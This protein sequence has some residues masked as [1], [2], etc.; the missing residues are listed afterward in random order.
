MGEASSLVCSID[1]GAKWR[2][3]PSTPHSIDSSKRA[4]SRQSSKLELPCERAAPSL[5][6]DCARRCPRAQRCEGGVRTALRRHALAAAESAMMSRPSTDAR[7]PAWAESVLR[8]LL[9]SRNRDSVSGDLLE[10]YRDVVLLSRGVLRAKSA[11]AS[12]REFRHGD[13]RWSCIDRLDEG[14]CH[15]RTSLARHAGVQPS[16]RGGP[17]DA[18]SFRRDRSG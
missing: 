11:C 3:A 17:A 5:L 13:K 16:R 7:P 15:V 18:I 9:P 12:A 14:G 1:S 8:L 6:R 4:L 10:E 2:Q